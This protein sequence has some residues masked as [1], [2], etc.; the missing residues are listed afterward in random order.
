MD[1]KTDKNLGWDIADT[2]SLI[3]F[4]IE[5]NEIP[6]TTAFKQWAKQN[7]RQ[8]FSVRNYFYKLIN[9]IKKDTSLCCLLEL[10]PKQIEMLTRKRFSV[11]DTT[12]LLRAVLP[13]RNQP[14]VR[15]ACMRLAEGDVSLMVRYQNKYRNVIKN[16]KTEVLK[17]M[18]YLRDLGIQVREPYKNRGNIISM[19]SVQKD[20][21]EVDIKALFMGLV[22]LIKRNT[23]RELSLKLA[24]EAQFSNDTLQ[25]VLIDLR[26]KHLMVEELKEQNKR[27]KKNLVVLQSNLAK[28]QAQSLSTML[29]VQSLV[30]SEKM[31]DLKSFFG[32]LNLEQAVEKVRKD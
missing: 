24:R 13:I 21:T 9:K 7:A 20:I 2:K 19:P 8:T 6:F 1:K 28:S 14:S 17:V 12:K 10:T 15:S 5:N 16:N 23:Q 26:R 29:Q 30:H 27:L 11:Q 3:N 18:R 22:N 31:Q 32:K 4:L 25:K